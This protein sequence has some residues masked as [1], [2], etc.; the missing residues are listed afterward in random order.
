[1]AM[2]AMLM[3]ATKWIK[4]D[5]MNERSFLNPVPKRI[6][7]GMKRQ[8]FVVGL[9]LAC[10]VLS[11]LGCTKR[12]RSDSSARAPE[13]FSVQ[14]DHPSCRKIYSDHPVITAQLKN[15]SHFL[16][17]RLD[18]EIIM[19]RYG[20]LKPLAQME[21]SLLFPSGI[22]Q[23][24]SDEIQIRIE[25]DPIISLLERADLE[26]LLRPTRIHVSD[27]SGNVHISDMRGLAT[28]VIRD[29]MELSGKLDNSP[30]LAYEK[31]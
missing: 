26:L 17:L 21:H 13:L 2:G 10:A 25:H 5:D 1:M 22:G 20:Q 29:W 12:E 24:E 7:F 27:R 14:I 15:N 11:A 30:R 28:V 31:E 8:H 6:G 4:D 23:D 19:S 16:L 9:W 3:T 18:I